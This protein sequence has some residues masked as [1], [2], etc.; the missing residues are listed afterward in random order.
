MGYWEYPSIAH[1]YQ[2]PIVVTGFEPVDILHGILLTIRQLEQGRAEAENAYS[3]GGI[4]SRAIP[5]PRL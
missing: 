2:V 1:Q 4:I 3:R 5:R